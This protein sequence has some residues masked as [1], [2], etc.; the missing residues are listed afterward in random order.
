ML[1]MVFVVVPSG[2]AFV[3][4]KSYRTARL[5]SAEG[6]A[7]APDGKIRWDKSTP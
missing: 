5:R 1:A 4:W 6:H 7:Y 2:I 3:I